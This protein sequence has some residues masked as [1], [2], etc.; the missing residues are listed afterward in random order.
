MKKADLVLL[1]F[2]IFF[3]WSCEKTKQ[4]EQISVDGS[5]NSEKKTDLISQNQKDIERIE[6]VKM[7]RKMYRDS[8]RQSFDIDTFSILDVNENGVE[9]GL[10]FRNDKGE[11]VFYNFLDHLPYDISSIHR[12]GKGSKREWHFLLSELDLS[13]KEKILSNAEPF[14]GKSLKEAQYGYI[15]MMGG[16][17]SSEVV[18]PSSYGV[19]IYGITILND[20]HG[21]ELG[22]FTIMKIF[23]KAGK[24]TR[25]MISKDIDASSYEISPDGT[26]LNIW[27]GGA[28][29]EGGGLKTPIHS[30]VYQISTGDKIWDAKGEVCGLVDGYITLGKGGTRYFIN[31][32]KGIAYVMEDFDKLLGDMIF[33]SKEYIQLVDR[34]LYF[35]DLPVIPLEQLK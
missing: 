30:Q 6:Q 11:D 33:F 32:E 1:C 28:Y 27:G 9:I 16:V 7:M 19:M 4:P 12:E 3:N 31:I 24:I 21:I 17:R 15:R 18:P 29:G 2:F 8:A 20:I 10:M 14:D 25:E 34:K 23:N 35:K 13:T 22:G 5:E 26:L